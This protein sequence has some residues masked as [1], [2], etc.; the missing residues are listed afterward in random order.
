MCFDCDYYV[1]HY[2]STEHMSLYSDFSP[3]QN[4]KIGL[5]RT[6]D[7]T[8]NDLH[9]VY[10]HYHNIIIYIYLMFKTIYLKFSATMIYFIE[11]YNCHC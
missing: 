10:F 4:R 7:N 3:R 5:L 1:Y 11:I 9:F 6:E 8:F 2:K